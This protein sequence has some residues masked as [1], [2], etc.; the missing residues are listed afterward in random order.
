CND[1]FSSSMVLRMSVSLLLDVVLPGQKLP[2]IKVKMFCTI[3]DSVPHVALLASG[4]G[5]R[6][7]VGLVG[8]LHQMKEDHLLDT[9]LYIG[10]RWQRIASSIRCVAQLFQK[11]PPL[12]PAV[13]RRPVESRQVFVRGTW[14]KQRDPKKVK[15]SEVWEHFQL[16]Q[17]KTCNVCRSDLLDLR[18]LSHDAVGEATNPYP[19]YCAVEKRKWFEL[20]PHEAGFTELG[21]FVHTSLLDSKF[22]RGDLL[23]KKPA[24][25]MV[26]L[27]GALC[28]EF[29]N[30]FLHK[31][32]EIR[33]SFSYSGWVTCVEPHCPPSFSCF[34]HVTH[35][36]LVDLILTMKPSGSPEDSLPPRLLRDV[37]PAVPPAVLDI[38]NSSFSSGVF[39]A[40]FKNAV[41]QP[42][43][44]KP[45]LDQSDCASYH[46]GMLI[47]VAYPSFLGDKRDIDL[48]IAQEYSAGNMFET[49]TLARDYADEVMKP[50][51]EIDE[52][53]LKD[54]DFPKDFY[55][56]EGKGKEPTI[57]YM[58]LFNRRNCKDEEDFKAKREEF[59]T[60]QLPFSQDKIQSLLEIAKANIRNN[61]EALLEEMRKA[62][63][64]RQSKRLGGW[65]E[66]GRGG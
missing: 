66:C 58:P 7:A 23:E 13:V 51:P 16:N 10:G 15:T 2:D 50:F 49:L 27:Q 56:F 24:M 47:N 52:T 35:S 65:S 14:Q 53:I 30:F 25:D 17:A 32:Q 38:V 45:G 42:L 20:T 54:R 44:N 64:R 36:S 6:A 60:F 61:R 22:Q 4:G 29:Q 63:L 59:S 48:I 28:N 12:P 37:L 3:Q 39:P 21:L 33:T 11:P 19:I 57:V 26:R 31:I 43:L 62:A 1:L 46:A 40:G 8:T 55:V 41:V 9:L 5:Q 34:A 18:N